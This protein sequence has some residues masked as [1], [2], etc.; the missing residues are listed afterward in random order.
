MSSLNEI[1]DLMA[2]IDKGYNEYRQLVTEG[3]SQ[4]LYHFTSIRAGF[5]ICNE[6]TIYFQSA[7]A[8]ESDNYDKKRKF[9]L[10]CTRMFNSRVGYSAQFNHGGVRITLD[11]D[12]L[13]QRFK[14]KQINY[15]GVG[16]LTDKYKYYEDFPANYNDLKRRRSFSIYN[17]LGD[18]PSEEEI[19]KYLRYNFDP[20]GQTHTY[21]E[22]EDRIFSYEPSLPNAHEYI[23]SIDVLIL[24]LDND[25][26]K[27]KIAQ[28]F[29]STTLSNKIKIY[30][31]VEEFNKPNGKTVND[32]LCNQ[33]YDD[34]FTG[35]DLD[36]KTN[37][38]YSEL[39]NVILFIATENDAFKGKNFGA[40]VSNLLTKY[41]LSE[42]KN[43][44]GEMQSDFSRVPFINIKD[45]LYI[46]RRDLSGR[47]DRITSKILKMLTDYCLSI[48]ANSLYEAVK[49]KEQTIE[50]K[51][52]KTYQRI[53]TSVK[54]PF[55]VYNNYTLVINPTKD[56][57]RDV[58]NGNQEDL[59]SLANDI[60]TEVMDENGGY[61]SNGKPYNTT[62]KNV[63]S[64]FQYI[65]KLLT[66]GSIQQVM[67][68]FNKLGLTKEYLDMWNIEFKTEELDYWQATNYDTVN[69]KKYKDANQNY[70][71]RQL[72]KMGD[73]EIEKCFPPIKNTE[74][75][76]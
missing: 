45:S 67:D 29:L 55:L 66:T 26:N 73:M 10:S 74:G 7:Y 75:N 52:K 64:M 69:M 12:K 41:G 14:G 28:S 9:Y 19:E 38:H 68:T 35:K 56:L 48:G 32:E 39:K 42:Y 46:D 47:P 33:Y 71:Y 34:R 36:T 22:S 8:K 1:K 18:S 15:W 76:I 63:N 61:Y 25:E 5:N 4:I 6:D 57:F 17:D 50:N 30:N 58:Y 2:R 21:N 60:A 20:V 16:N 49:I 70:N 62:S 51:Y 13:S 3:M 37:R 54:V 59:R 44:I 43:E 53:D 11:G 24:N 31:S 72:A 23:I 27:R 40:A 65:F